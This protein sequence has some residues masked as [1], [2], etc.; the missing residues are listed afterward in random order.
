MPEEHKIVP[1]D[2]VQLKCGGSRMMACKDSDKG[3]IWCEWE[4]AKGEHQISE[5]FIVSLDWI[6]PSKSPI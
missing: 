3:K 5:F 1:G 4:N 2:I 6:D